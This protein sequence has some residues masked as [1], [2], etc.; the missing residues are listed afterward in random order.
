MKNKHPAGDANLLDMETNKEEP[1]R[2]Q[3][4]ELTSR[5]IQNF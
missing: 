2:W 1:E 5:D 4:V 3:P